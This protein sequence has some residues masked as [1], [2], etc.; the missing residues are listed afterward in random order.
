MKKPLNQQVA[1]GDLLF[2]P[3]DD[4]EFSGTPV[5]RDTFDRYILARGEA[6][7]HLH[8]IDS[9]DV[10]IKER[11]GV[12]Y[13]KVGAPSEVR[14]ETA[15]KVLTMEHGTLTLKPGTWKLNRQFEWDQGAR[16]SAD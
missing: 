14:H 8:A 9:P 4:A 12:M 5:P 16:L 15:P 13:L 6:T 3:V 11:G 1:Q 10:E 2:V 7:G